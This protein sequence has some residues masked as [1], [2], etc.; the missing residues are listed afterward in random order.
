[1]SMCSY[2]KTCVLVTYCVHLL[3]F[4][5]GGNRFKQSL[6]H[7]RK[8]LCVLNIRPA[9]SAPYHGGLVSLSNVSPHQLD[10]LGCLAETKTLSH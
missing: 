4:V 7:S 8:P 1:M 9:H 6:D 5:L 10:F 2:L 3:H